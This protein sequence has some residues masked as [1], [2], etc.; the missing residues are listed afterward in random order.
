MYVVHVT[1]KLNDDIRFT[2]HNKHTHTHTPHTTHHTHTHTHTH[3]PHDQ[4]KILHSP[5][6][7]LLFPLVLVTVDAD[8]SSQELSQLVHDV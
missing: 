7:L 2:V 8:G 6:Y 5:H 3:T 1:D 4:M